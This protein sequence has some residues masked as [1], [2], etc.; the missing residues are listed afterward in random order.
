[1]KWLSAEK[2]LDLLSPDRDLRGFDL[3]SARLRVSMDYDLY[4]KNV[5]YSMQ[6]DR[7]IMIMPNLFSI[8]A[9]SYLL[10]ESSAKNKIDFWVIN[11]TSEV[12]H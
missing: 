1:M 5:Y 9:R 3:G 7:K 11:L 10:S 12:T 6:L 8:D 2:Q 4:R